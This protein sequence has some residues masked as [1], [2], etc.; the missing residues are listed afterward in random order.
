MSVTLHDLRNR[1]VESNPEQKVEI[2]GRHWGAIYKGRGGPGLVMLPGTL[3]RASIFWQQFEALCD[4]AR[5]LGVSYPASHDMG[6]WADDLARLLD[7]FKMERAT[8]MGSSLGGYLAQL[9]AARHPDR[10]DVLIAANTLSTTTGLAQK[11]PYAGD[12]AGIPIAKLRRGFLRGLKERQKQRPFE[13]ELYELL[14]PEVEGGISGRHLRARLLAL[15]HAPPLP[16]VP[17]PSS[18]IVV[19]E[20]E[21]D[22]LVIPK[23]RDDVRAFLAPAVTYRF[24]RGGH[25]PYVMRPDAYLSILE[26]QM[27][28]NVSGPDW[29]TCMVRVR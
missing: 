9:F 7:F 20:S 26:E 5:L 17:L 2:R 23:V 28:L 22:P 29:G 6:Q 27:G 25:F 13:R 4:H 19:I 1:F 12:L 21:D 3:G 18:R 14:F 15:K 8:V 16:V 10:V 11:P 24:I